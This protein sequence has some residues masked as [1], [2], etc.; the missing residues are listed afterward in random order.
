MLSDT[1]DLNGLPKASDSPATGL[2]RE[3]NSFICGEPFAAVRVMSLEM[4]PTRS[5]ELSCDLLHD[6]STNGASWQLYLS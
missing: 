4:I 3:E 1:S 2:R 5:S 6:Q